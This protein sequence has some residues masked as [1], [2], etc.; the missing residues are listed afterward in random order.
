MAA[1]R[2]LGQAEL[3]A[4]ALVFSALMLTSQLPTQMSLTPAEARTRYLATSQRIGYLLPN[5]RLALPWALAGALL[6]VSVGWLMPS[7]VP[8][9]AG[10][11]LAG[12]VALAAFF[13]PDC[14]TTPVVSSI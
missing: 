10:W 14:R 6:T 7:D 1:T 13:S 11:L 2:L 4:Y 9:Y 5:L 8:A 3:G 12:L